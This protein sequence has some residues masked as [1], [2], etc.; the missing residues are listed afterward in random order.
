MIIR[1]IVL[2]LLLSCCV[3]PEA[4]SIEPG[5]Y[6]SNTDK[7]HSLSGLVENADRK[8]CCTGID[9]I[10]I[11]VSKTD[12]IPR[13]PLY[14][15]RAQLKGFL[16]QERKKDFIVVYLRILRSVPFEPDEKLAAELIDFIAP[17][18]YKRILIVK[19]GSFGNMVIKDWCPEPCTESDTSKNL[20]IKVE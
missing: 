15:S 12:S 4:H 19:D 9:E 13:E 18:G 20:P 16:K 7:W 10:D 3:I 1:N 14:L 5:W 6:P 17:L 2:Q 8:L 11:G